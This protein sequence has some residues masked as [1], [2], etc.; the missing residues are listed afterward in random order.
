MCEVG[1]VAELLRLY[2]EVPRERS[3]RPWLLANMV[4]GLDGSA[5]VGGRVG[6]LST[7]PDAA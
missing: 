1:G 4:G 5:A 2:T 7:G 3:G 6:S